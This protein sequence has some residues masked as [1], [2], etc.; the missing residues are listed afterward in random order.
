MAQPPTERENRA[1][2]PDGLREEVLPLVEENLTIHKRTVETGVV[3]V[4]TVVQ[5]REELARADLYRHAVSVERVP[6]NREID[7]V[8]APW[9]EG[10]LLVIPVVEEVVVIEKRLILREEIRVQR[11]REVE[12]VEQPVR[13]RSVQAL[14][15]R[16]GA[17]A[18]PRA[19]LTGER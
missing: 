3:R 10:D 15:E 2:A 1:H 4:R 7:T 18:S 5:E 11:R 13:L 6:I 17:A 12:T 16:E 14:V 8:P 19:P 9:E